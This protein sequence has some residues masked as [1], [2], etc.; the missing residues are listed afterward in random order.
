MWGVTHPYT[1]FKAFNQPMENCIL[2]DLD[3][4]PKI[5]TSVYGNKVP[6]GYEEVMRSIPPE[7]VI[8][9]VLENL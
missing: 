3:L 7:K 2:P 9:K 6:E 4:Y 8:Q 5:P 1:G